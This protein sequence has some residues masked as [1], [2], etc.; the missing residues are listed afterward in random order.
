[1][2]SIDAL[3]KNSRLFDAESGE[4]GLTMEKERYA[5]FQGSGMFLIVSAGPSG[6]RSSGLWP[7]IRLL[8][9]HLSVKL[10]IFNVAVNRGDSLK[11]SVLC[12]CSSKVKLTIRRDTC[13][14]IVISI[15]MFYRRV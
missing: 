14:C 5:A 6:S 1:M 7:A 4:K 12:D 8:D 9:E 13:R 11:V 15:E 3:E 10:I 2:A